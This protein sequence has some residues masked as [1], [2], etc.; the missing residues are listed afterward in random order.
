[1]V[2]SVKVFYHR[3]VYKSCGGFEDY[4]IDEE[5]SMT[6][7]I[8]S[9]LLTWKQ[10]PT[11]CLTLLHLMKNLQPKM[12][13]FPRSLLRKVSQS[14]RKF[15]R[16]LSQ[17]KKLNSVDDF[18]FVNEGTKEKIQILFKLKIWL[19]I[20]FAENDA[21]TFVRRYICERQITFVKDRVTSS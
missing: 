6:V 5:A 10:L 8:F 21:I 13:K 3:N 20:S 7:V 19:T 16:S 12:R 15:T 17:K 18:K 2:S 1:M 4:I 9:S 11:K 14:M